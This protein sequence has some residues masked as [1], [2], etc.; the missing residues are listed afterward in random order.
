MPSKDRIRTFHV[1]RSEDETGVSGTGR[2]MEGIEFPSG[3][4]VVEWQAPYQTLGI[5]SS[6]AEFSQ[7]HIDSHPSK[8]EVIFDDN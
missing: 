3:R 5:Y 7:I 4:V 2:I 8:S 6:F 1:I